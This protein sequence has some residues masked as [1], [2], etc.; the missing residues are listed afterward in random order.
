MATRAQKTK[1][2]IFLVACFV[3]MGIGFLLIS[4]YRHGAQTRYHIFF[5][6]SV[7]G[8]NVGGLVEYSGVPVGR[9]GDIN[10][11]R[12]RNVRVDIVVDDDEIAIHEGVEAQLVMYSIATGTMA[13]SLSG[14]DFQADTLPPGAEI[15]SRPSLFASAAGHLPELLNTI[16]EIA[17]KIDLGLHGI[18]E[19]QLQRM[20]EETEGAVRDVRN[21][22]SESA[23]TLHDLR[24][25][26]SNGVEDA[27]KLIQE[28]SD[29][30]K[31]FAET[32]TE[33]AKSASE[34]LALLNEKLA[35]LDVSQ[36]EQEL[37][38]TLRSV[39]DLAEAVTQMTQ[40]LDTVTKTTV[41][42]VDNVEFTVRETMSALTETLDALRALAVTLRQDPS[43]IVYG[44]ARPRGVE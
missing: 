14:G 12:D 24:L 42:Q 10:V 38:A 6:E 44:P 11:T 29:E 5:D 34:T 37:Q 27:R 41:Y 15:P 22:F 26:I 1:V 3:I 2:G 19:G 16:T 4:G 43:A 32:S 31:P 13:V 18:E 40:Q 33:L 21:V 7:L 23:E 9:V 30:I 36:T 17:E 39:R 25:S 28:V 20:L 35:A 8:L